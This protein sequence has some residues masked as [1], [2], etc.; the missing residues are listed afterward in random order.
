MCVFSVLQCFCE[1]LR[2]LVLDSDLILISDCR[3][4]DMSP[5]ASCPR[6]WTLRLLL[7]ALLMLTMMTSL[8]VS[9]VE[10]ETCFSRQHQSVI[11]NVRLALNRPTT[12]MDARGVRSERD[13]VLA[14]C[15]EE[16]KP[17]EMNKER[18]E[19]VKVQV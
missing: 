3:T 13:C 19:N 2:L 1:D 5:P 6:S 15:S 17:G 9:A 8:P 4:A 18:E 12:V 10:A 14:C 16:V 7:T 11:V